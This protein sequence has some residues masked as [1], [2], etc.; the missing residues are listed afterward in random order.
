MSDLA[1]PDELD[2][3]DS[4]KRETFFDETCAICGSFMFWE[5]CWNGCED[6]YLDCFEEDPMW[7]DEGDVRICDVC[8]GKGGFY[9]CSNT[10]NHP[11]ATRTP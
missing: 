4:P 5:D 8:E 3:Q 2:Y 7:Y 11:T 10:K 9:I 6:G 1:R